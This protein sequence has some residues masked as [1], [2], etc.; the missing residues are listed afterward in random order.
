MAR[1]DCIGQN[2]RGSGYIFVMP[3]RERSLLLFCLLACVF[4]GVP[5][6]ADPGDVESSHDYPGWPRMP[7]YLITDYD[8]D[9]PGA[10]TF[11]VARPLPID[12]NH[13]EA[14]PVNG[15]RYVIRYEWGPAGHAPSLLAAQ[16]YY[17]K[18]AVAAGFAVEKSGAVG[19]VTETFH[20]AKAGRQVWVYL[21]PSI[22]ANVL[23]I[24]ESRVAVAPS[25]TT[26]ASPPVTAPALQS[27]GVPPAAAPFPVGVDP[28]GTAL[29]K[30]GRVVLPLSFLPGKPDLD[31]DS[32]PVIDRVVAILK[33]HPDLMLTIEGHT[34]QTGDA[35]ANLLLSKERARTVR[36]L[37]IA[38]HVNRKRLFAVGLGG[39]Q[40]LADESTP[41]GR[42]KNRRIELVVR[43]TDKDSPQ[44]DSLGNDSDSFHSPAPDGVNYYPSGGAIPPA[45]S[46]APPGSDSS[47]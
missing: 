20:Q 16:R 2:G 33:L 10:F 39:S 14:V 5:I 41:E 12:A 45:P 23:T 44:K 15:H 8:E 17:E 31:A 27:A 43:K 19:D 24:V 29:M 22:T 13:V 7:G 37:L 1:A 9:N 25:P 47:R 21:D 46:P 4:V 11:P 18:L 32:Q 28:L 6:R 38:S 35:Q 40:P 30:N 42:E 26:T 36:G 34:D 3:C